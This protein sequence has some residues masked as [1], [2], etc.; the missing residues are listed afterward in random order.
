MRGP[1]ISARS[2]TSIDS[3]DGGKGYS[4]INHGTIIAQCPPTWMSARWPWRSRAPRPPTSPASAGLRRQLAFR[5]PGTLVTTGGLLN[6]GTIRAQAITKED[7]TSN[8]GATAVLHRR[9]RHHSPD[10]CGRRIRQR[11]QLHPRHHQRRRSAVR[12]AASPPPSQISNQAMVPQI[13]VLQHGTHHRQHPTSTHLARR[14]QRDRGL[15]LHPER[16]RDRRSVRQR[17]S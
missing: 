4:F 17:S 16:H 1:A 6:T 7:T 10:R 3:V 12:A 11:Q 8:L 15:A 13:D 14:H 2:L 9:L 5:N